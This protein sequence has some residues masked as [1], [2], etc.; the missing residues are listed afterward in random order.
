MSARVGS[1]SDNKLGGW[2]SY[3]AAKAGLNQLLHGASIELKRTHK[4]TILLALHPGTVETNFTANYRAKDKLTP[5][6]AAQR[7]LE[8]IETRSLSDTGKFFD[9]AGSEIPW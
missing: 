7:L 2:H 1:I 9:H 5:D 3:R 4:Q 6:E 8:V